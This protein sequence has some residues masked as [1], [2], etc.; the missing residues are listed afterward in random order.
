MELHIVH[1]VFK[2]LYISLFLHYLPINFPR[3]EDSGRWSNIPVCPV[4]SIDGIT[5]V[6]RLGKKSSLV[7][8]IQPHYLIGCLWASAEFSTRGDSTI[9][10]S[11]STRLLEWITYHLY[12]AKMDHIYVYDNTEAFTNVTSLEKVLNLFPSDRVTRIKWKHRVCCNNRPMHKNA[13]E[14]SSQYAA[15]TSC[16][17]RY[18]PMTEWIAQ[19]DVD[20][21]LIPAG[22]W[23][24]I[25]SWLKGSVTTG[26]IQ[27][28]TNI[29]SFFSNTCSTKY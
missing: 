19:L 5:E 11:T 25:Q 27:N 22:H 16:R 21:Y 15:E 1:L 17:L 23:T 26:K 29:L 14:R 28:K 4:S 20:E 6:S 12:I 2:I 10:K 9:D 24:D 7:E 18:G 8:N 3:V 13:G